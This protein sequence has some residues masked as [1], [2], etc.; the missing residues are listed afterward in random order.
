L[1]TILSIFSI[2]LVWQLCHTASAQSNDVGSQ[3]HAT[4]RFLAWDDEGA[5]LEPTLWIGKIGKGG[6]HIIQD[7]DC[8]DMTTVMTYRGPA[9]LVFTL[10]NAIPDEKHT[11]TLK[12][13]P[14]WKKILVLVGK[15]KKSPSG[16]RMMALNHSADSFPWGSYRIINT[17]GK[18][19]KMRLDQKL[20][21]IP[22]TRK[23]VTVKLNRQP[24]MIK[25]LA[26]LANSNSPFFGCVS[27][28]R[29]DTRKILIFSRQADRRLGPLALRIIP[30]RKVK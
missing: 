28:H 17:T 24:G 27:E 29:L 13:N 21:P 10:G 7:L 2:L 26:T 5:K 22:K 14:E 11:Y 12:V 30:E 3:A 20:V 8:F 9:S 25:M 19:L 16:L 6:K 1:K 15:D 23:S 4:I 18:A